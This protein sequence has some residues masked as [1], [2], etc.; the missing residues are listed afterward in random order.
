LLVSARK[1]GRDLP[2]VDVIEKNE[3]KKA[4]GLLRG[5]RRGKEGLSLGPQ[6]YLK[7]RKEEGSGPPFSMNFSREGGGEKKK[8]KS[9]L[10]RLQKKSPARQ[11]GKKGGDALVGLREFRIKRDVGIGL[12]ELNWKGVPHQRITQ[13]RLHSIRI[14]RRREKNARAIGSTS[15]ALGR[16]EKERGPFCT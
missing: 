14:K 3:E 16:G 10:F 12:L 2:N 6:N 11:K 1:K 8:K 9:G 7:L 5:G 4:E 13:Q 15:P